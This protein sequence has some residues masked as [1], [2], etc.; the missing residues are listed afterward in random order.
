MIRVRP[1]LL[2]FVVAVFGAIA[3]LAP[4]AVAQN[5]IWKPLVAP[6]MPQAETTQFDQWVPLDDGTSYAITFEKC[7]PTNEF[8]QRIYITKVLYYL[9]VRVD[10]DLVFTNTNP[11]GL[12]S[13]DMGWGT[14]GI[15]ARPF[16]SKLPLGD[17]AN[18]SPLWHTGGD[19]AVAASLTWSQLAAGQSVSG[20]VRGV[21]NMLFEHRV[22]TD[23][24]RKWQGVGSTTFYVT[25]DRWVAADVEG[26]W[27]VAG[28]DTMRVAVFGLS[29]AGVPCH[30]YVGYEYTTTPPVERFSIVEGPWSE[31]VAIDADNADPQPI[32][33]HGYTGDPSRVSA[34]WLE[35]MQSNRLPRWIENTTPNQ[36]GICGGNGELWAEWL[37]PT[38]VQSV[39]QS[40][41]VG[42]GQQLVSPFDNVLD[43]LGAS[44][45]TTPANA[46][47]AF[48][49][50]IAVD[51][52]L[53]PYL[54]NGEVDVSMR[55]VSSNIAPV[56]ITP[57]CTFAWSG[58][59]YAG[60]WVRAVT[61]KRL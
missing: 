22:G 55:V 52:L 23:E 51:P 12:P 57:G 49:A 48:R 1:L 37:F 24:Y 36:G 41:G 3:L 39:H 5:V 42:S 44:G 8:G 61:K 14:Y 59:W 28:A 35:L 31:V 16:L 13:S 56:A 46:G 20:H 53:A 26:H 19:Q 17:D 58:E 30:G 34:S 47:Y 43:G 29:A 21:G 54:T 4:G 50:T 9:D 25:L 15:G 40:T 7:P 2:L 18:Y 45:R 10:G 32:T 6:T 11:A 38:G 33:L 27:S 60:G